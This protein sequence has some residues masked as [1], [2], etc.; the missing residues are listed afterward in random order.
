[1]KKIVFFFALVALAIAL[2]WTLFPKRAT[3]LP[4][5]QITA[6]S[7]NPPGTGLA[8][9][10]IAFQSKII[11]NTGTNLSANEI[12]EEYHKGNIK[13]GQAM[14]QIFLSQNKNLDLYGRVIDQYGQPVA[15]AKI[16][17]NVVVRRGF[18]QQSDE[19]HFTQTDEGGNFSFLGFNGTGLGIWPQKVGYFYNLK[20]P[21]KRPDDYNPNPDNPVIF[22][23]WKLHG[24]E[25]LVSSSLDA[26]IP[27]DGT[28]TR[29][30]I[31]TGRQ[32][33]NGDLQ[34]TLIRSPLAVQRG[35]DIFNWTVG[36]EIL[37]GGVLPQN[38]PYPYWAPENGYQP[39]YEF[40]MSS[41]NLPWSSSLDCGFYIK[42]AR[43]QYGVMQAK[44][45][46]ALTPARVQFNFTFNPSGSQNL[47]PAIQQ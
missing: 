28:P 37:G 29:F 33:A 47:E 14:Q 35:R 10:P 36:I 1:M 18:M 20:L 24:P 45:Y 9:N 12:L 25:Q 16:Q 44:V 13:K 27:F 23:M 30:D 5:R 22:T 40:D 8:T 43:G 3:R 26:K 11:T 42:N 17:G 39:L 6:L 19:V 38:D 41:N 7:T 21:S 4:M 46:A 34:I 32:S 15:G 2:F 31:A